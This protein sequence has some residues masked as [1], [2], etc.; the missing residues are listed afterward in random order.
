M[1]DQI[2]VFDFTKRIPSL[3]DA[4]EMSMAS[5]FTSPVVVSWE[6]IKIDKRNEV[7]FD[8]CPCDAV[9]NPSSFIAD[10]FRHTEQCSFQCPSVIFLF[11]IWQRVDGHCMQFLWCVVLEEIKDHGVASCVIS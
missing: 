8:K 3:M 5:P 6:S 9:R 11:A 1:V 2:I 10:N 4:K 7:D